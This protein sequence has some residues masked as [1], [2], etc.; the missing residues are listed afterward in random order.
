MVSK[1]LEIVY[2]DMMSLLAFSWEGCSSCSLCLV[3]N[4]FIFRTLLLF[5]GLFL[6]LL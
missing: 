1:R 5:L 6:L 3:S 4:V 2:L